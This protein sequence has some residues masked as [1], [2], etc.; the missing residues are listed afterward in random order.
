MK[1][2][3]IFSKGKTI[4]VADG[5]MPGAYFIS[6]KEWPGSGFEDLAQLT[7]GTFAPDATLR[8]TIE[9]YQPPD[10]CRKVVAYWYGEIVR[11]V[12]EGLYDTGTCLND[13]GAEAWLLARM[14]DQASLSTALLRKFASAVQVDR[15]TGQIR[16][17]VPVVSSMTSSELSRLF[18]PVL[19][20]TFD[21]FHQKI[22][23]FEEFEWR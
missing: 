21:T 12:R 20:W 16:E 3:K 14:D 5:K 6:Q 19:V 1:L 23:L 11:L 18:Y 7:L 13:S 4:L 9:E 17:V 22:T 2:K 15:Q 8:I 10:L